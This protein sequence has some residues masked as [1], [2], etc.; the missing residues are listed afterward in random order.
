[1]FMLNSNHGDSKVSNLEKAHWEETR[2]DRAD[3]TSTFSG[4]VVKVWSHVVFSLKSSPEKP[5]MKQSA[6]ALMG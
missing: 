3:K 1:M 6:E 2:S 5:R 4:V